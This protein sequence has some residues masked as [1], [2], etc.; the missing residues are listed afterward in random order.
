MQRT[1]ALRDIFSMTPRNKIAA[2][3]QAFKAPSRRASPSPGSSST[4]GLA[5]RRFGFGLYS[6]TISSQ[7]PHAHMMEQR[8]MAIV[9]TRVRR[10]DGALSI[11]RPIAEPKKIVDRLLIMPL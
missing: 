1:L 8:L 3:A 6:P 9:V 5:Y 11:Q 10:C 2:K 7:K 4:K